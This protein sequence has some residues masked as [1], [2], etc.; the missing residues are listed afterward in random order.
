[1]AYTDADTALHRAFNCCERLYRNPSWTRLFKTSMSTGDGT[2]DMERL[3]EDACTLRK[4]RSEMDKPYFATLTLMYSRT[5]DNDQK[6]E[7]IAEIRPLTSR[8]IGPY[9][10]KINRQF[11]ELVTVSHL[12]QLKLPIKMTDSTL[13]KQ[14]TKITGALAGLEKQA[15]EQADRILKQYE[16][17]D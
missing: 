10:K 2:T 16:L 6:R 9:Q 11:Y 15:R 17:I 4:L 12:G 7:C 3:A 5:I 14:K 13:C 8:T 1:M